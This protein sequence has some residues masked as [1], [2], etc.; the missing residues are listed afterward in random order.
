MTGGSAICMGA[1][2]LR[3]LVPWNDDGNSS[4][5]LMILA[6]FC[7]RLDGGNI[8]GSG[9][10]FFKCVHFKCIAIKCNGRQM[11][12]NDSLRLYL[13]DLLPSAPP[14]P[15]PTLYL[16]PS[17]PRIRVQ[18]LTLISHLFILI[19]HGLTF[20]FKC[21]RPRFLSPPKRWHFLAGIS[22]SSAALRRSFS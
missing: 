7:S 10:W 21:E 12:G 2:Y 1:M 3:C 4:K 6:T 16:L 13:L 20:L 22:F 15:H 19:I 5:P 18:D 14:H 8:L 9:W 17:P 11:A